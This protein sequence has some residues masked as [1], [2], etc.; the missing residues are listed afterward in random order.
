MR[1][2]KC[3]NENTPGASACFGCGEAIH[4]STN[5]GD[6]RKLS[7]LSDEAKTKCS[8]RERAERS[9]SG[10]K[11]ARLD[12][13]Q[14][15][16][17]LLSPLPGLGFLF[18]RRYF[19]GAGLFIVFAICLRSLRLVYSTGLADFYDG[20]TLP[21]SS[22]YLGSL[23]LQ[24][25]LTAVLFVGAILSERQYRMERGRK[26]VYDMALFLGMIILLVFTTGQYRQVIEGT[27][28]HERTFAVAPRFD[29]FSP[30]LRPDDLLILEKRDI[31]RLDYVLVDATYDAGRVV[32]L[33]N[34]SYQAR[35]H[36]IPDL[37]LALEG[38]TVTLSP[39]GAKLQDGR[40]VPAE[41]V[42][43]D[44][45]RAFTDTFGRREIVVK[46]PE[47]RCLLAL[48]MFGLASK[49]DSTPPEQRVPGFS[50]RSSITSVVA[51]TIEPFG[52]SG[53]RP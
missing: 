44:Y 30:K 43:K 38:D 32:K 3:G 27:R 36:A 5:E 29:F 53:R 18:L 28:K 42:F 6:L 50:S 41:D 24:F 1:C 7:S 47:G 34:I 4:E 17:V 48:L 35:A 39:S 19:T 8:E 15:V 31:R 2:R 40:F 45:G 14:L 11:L 26:N 9:L 51:K 10:A 23:V 16:V 20:Y 13:G 12:F 46:V 37:V 49:D 25:V 21:R 22:C 52:R 33:P